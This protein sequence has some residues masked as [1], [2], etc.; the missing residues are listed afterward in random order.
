MTISAATV[1]QMPSRLGLGSRWKTREAIEVITTT[2]ARTKRSTPAIRDARFA[3]R[4]MPFENCI[5]TTVARDKISSGTCDARAFAFAPGTT[6]M[7]FSPL[8]S[9]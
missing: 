9:T 8:A 3:F 7:Q 6:V 4:R 5:S 1:M 2:P